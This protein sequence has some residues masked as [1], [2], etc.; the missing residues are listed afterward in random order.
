MGKYTA[1][2]RCQ[3]PCLIALFSIIALAGAPSAVQSQACVQDLFVV[4]QDEMDLGSTT[5]IAY[6]NGGRMTFRLETGGSADDA[7]LQVDADGD[8]SFESSRA[9]AAKTTGTTSTPPVPVPQPFRFDLGART[10][11]RTVHLTLP[12]GGGAPWEWTVDQLPSWISAPSTGG[13]TPESVAVILG[14]GAAEGTYE[15]TFTVTVSNQGYSVE[16]PISVRLRVF[17]GEAILTRIQIVPDSVTL[18]VG[19]TIGFIASAFDQ[20]EIPM[21][22]DPVW[23][24]TGG[25]ID[26]G[27]FYTAGDVPGEYFVRAT[28]G[29]GTVVGEA[30]VDIVTTLS[31]ETWGSELPSKLVFESINPNPTSAWAT[32]RFALPAA[33]DVRLEVYDMLGRPVTVPLEGLRAAGSHEAVMGTAHL[34]VGVYLVRLIA[35]RESATRRIMVVR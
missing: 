1:S 4:L 22:L 11:G 19:G 29:S 23:S 14:A 25:Q 28:D 21:G 8:R 9:P 15:D 31:A 10:E 30:A 13:Q 3:G 33:A 16:Y 12:D 17:S 27:G 24:A 6:V 34:P 20:D 35:G 18:L 2:P 26:S 7:P 5:R 32:M